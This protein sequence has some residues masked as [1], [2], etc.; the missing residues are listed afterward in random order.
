MKQL[1]LPPF[2]FVKTRDAYGVKS[3]IPRTNGIHWLLF[4]CDNVSFEVSFRW[5]I[6]HYRN[7][8]VAYPTPHG[9]HVIVFKPS[10]FNEAI[11]ELLGNPYADINHVRI[12]I[13]RGYWFLET[14]IPITQK[15]V[16]YMRIERI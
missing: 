5:A 12:G 3:V 8:V 13:K 4:D 6:A 7:P 16:Q 10:T 11:G 1:H 9:S 14:Y 15:Q 2:L